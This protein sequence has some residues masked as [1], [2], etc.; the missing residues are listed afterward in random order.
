MKVPKLGIESRQIYILS[1][2][3]GSYE[4]NIRTA[5]L[6]LTIIA[7]CRNEIEACSIL[8]IGHVEIT[9]SCGF[10]TTLFTFYTL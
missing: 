8:Q 4:L 1:L 2:H 7:T 10:I 5:L 9:I 3:G 6:P